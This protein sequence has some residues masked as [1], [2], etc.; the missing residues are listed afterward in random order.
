MVH[1]RIDMRIHDLKVKPE[2]WNKYLKDE[3]WSIRNDDRNFQENDIC[4]FY[5]VRGVM[6]ED[7]R[8]IVKLVVKKT[9]GWGIKDGNCILDLKLWGILP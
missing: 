1:E 6:C 2:N 5:Q 7:E 8:V 3:S 9:T 4:V